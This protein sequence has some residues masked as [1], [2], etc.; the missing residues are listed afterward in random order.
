MKSA[1]DQARRLIAFHRHSAAIEGIAPP[2]EVREIEDAFLGGQISEDE[3][4]ARLRA[5]MPAS[6]ITPVVLRRDQLFEACRDGEITPL[7]LY[8]KLGRNG[9]QSV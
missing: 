5:A 1:P 4:L 9:G 8:K 6:W 3:F 2:P 7:T